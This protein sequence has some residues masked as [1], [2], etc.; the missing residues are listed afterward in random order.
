MVPLLL[1]LGNKRF[2]VSSS[3]RH[4]CAALLPSRAPYLRYDWR[5]EAWNLFLVGGMLLGGLLA[6]RLLPNAGPPAISERT[7][8]DLHALGIERPHALA[9]LEIFSWHGLVSGR[10]LAMIVL[11]GFLVGFGTR[12]ANGCTSGHAIS[13]LANLEWPS[14]VAVMGFFAGGLL[15]THALLPLFLR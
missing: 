9:P 5:A 13:G 12:Y 1:W 7:I 2:G 10:G 4:L 15:V 3:F 6:A 8:A 11:G 14:L